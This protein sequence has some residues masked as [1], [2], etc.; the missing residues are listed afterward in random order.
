MNLY[1][2]LSLDH[3]QEHCISVCQACHSNCLTTAMTMCLEKGGAL[4][5]PAHF[6][7]LMNCTE[8]WQTSANFMLSDSPMHHHLSRICSE[9]SDACIDSCEEIGQSE[10]ADLFQAHSNSNNSIPH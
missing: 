1:P 6:R 3:N 9:L 5:R 2:Q 7:S 8:L 10:Y 4:L